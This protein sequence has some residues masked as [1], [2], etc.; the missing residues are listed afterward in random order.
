[1]LFSFAIL[2]LTKTQLALF[3]MGNI[4]GCTIFDLISLHMLMYHYHYAAKPILNA[5]E[6]HA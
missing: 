3:I 4:N 6:S 2:E 5:E 1:M